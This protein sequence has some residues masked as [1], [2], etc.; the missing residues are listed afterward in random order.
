[1]RD[2]SGPSIVVPDYKVMALH[3]GRV[4]AS[5]QHPNLPAVVQRTALQRKGLDDATC[6]PMP[7]QLSSRAFCQPRDAKFRSHSF[8]NISMCHSTEY[9]GLTLSCVVDLEPCLLSCPGSSVGRA[10]CLESRVSWVRVFEKEVVL[11]G[12]AMHLPCTLDSYICTYIL[13]RTCYSA[14][15]KQTYRHADMY[16]KIA[17]VA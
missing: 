6:P 4:G 16:R 1:M 2:R 13:R 11:V 14:H 5:Q 15:H 7:R 12:I 3:Y 10:L 8:R 17:P 9:W